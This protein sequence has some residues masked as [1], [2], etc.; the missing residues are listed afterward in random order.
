MNAA[1]LFSA[2]YSTARRRFR[3]AASRLGWELEAHSINAKSPNGEELT[4]EAALSPGKDSDR[5]LIIS[6]GLHGVEGF[7]GSAVQSGLLEQWA[8]NA[9]MQLLVSRLELRAS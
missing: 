4:I 6:S 2:D 8:E 3:A 7:F 1:S 9:M 5:V